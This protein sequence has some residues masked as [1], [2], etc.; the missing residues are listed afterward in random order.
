MGANQ[1]KMEK[2]VLTPME[3]VM[4]QHPGQR[5]RI[6][7]CVTKWHKRTSGKNR[8]PK[9]GT[10]NLACCDEVESELRH[11]EAKDTKASYKKKN[12]RAKEREVLGWFRQV[13]GSKQMVQV[14]HSKHP[15][16]P[17]APTDVI[18]TAPPLPAPRPPPYPQDAS[19]SETGQ[20]PLRSVGEARAASTMEGQVEGRFT[21]T[22]AGDTKAKSRLKKTLPTRR[23][24]TMQMPPCAGAETEADAWTT[25]SEDGSEEDRE[26]GDEEEKGEKPPPT[27][28]QPRP[29]LKARDQTPRLGRDTSTLVT[30]ELNWAEQ[31]RRGKERIESMRR[32][33]RADIEQWRLLEQ[34]EAEAAQTKLFANSLLNEPLMMDA[35]HNDRRDRHQ[36][37][38]APS[39][40]VRDKDTGSGAATRM[41]RGA[42]HTCAEDTADDSRHGTIGDVP[43][44]LQSHSTR[45]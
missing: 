42:E 29:I 1:G 21:V 9:D 22:L 26:E 25:D 33:R 10:F 7:C 8:W 20:Y 14:E 38:A 31:Y 13:G 30:T 24:L 41:G 27:D 16:D 23:T 39:A 45:K 44:R 19:P 4:A 28:G 11:I 2:G 36:G 6:Q 17:Q 40:T 34:L 15:Q 43:E 18:P 3:I 5:N 32:Q 37:M 35:T 12:K